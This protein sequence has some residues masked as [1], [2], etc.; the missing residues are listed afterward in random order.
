M[1]MWK[2]DKYAGLFEDGGAFDIPASF[3]AGVAF[4]ANPDTTIMPDMPMRAI[5]WVPRM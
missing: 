3:T 5:R 1:H 4:K 2:F